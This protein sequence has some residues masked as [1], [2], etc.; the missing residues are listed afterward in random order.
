MGQQYKVEPFKF[1]DPPL[2]LEF[3]QAVEML[4]EAGEWLV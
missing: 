2:R 3:P 1:L 4:R